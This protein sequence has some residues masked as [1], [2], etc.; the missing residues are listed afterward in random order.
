M[1]D[2]THSCQVSQRPRLHLPF[3]DAPCISQNLLEFYSRRSVVLPSEV[4]DTLD[5]TEKSNRKESEENQYQKQIQK[6]IQK[7]KQTQKKT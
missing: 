1:I 6:Q 4:R 2:L 7:Q 3:S 5:L